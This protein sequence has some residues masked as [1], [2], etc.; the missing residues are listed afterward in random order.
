MLSHVK[1]VVL[2]E[3]CNAHQLTGA[4]CVS[5]QQRTDVAKVTVISN[6][7]LPENCITKQWLTFGTHQHSIAN[8][9]AKVALE[10]ADT[11]RCSYIA[12]WQ[13]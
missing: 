3:N 13:A 4:Q 7:V 1:S 5:A 9:V 11:G 12:L 6:V 2:P 8:Y 10:E